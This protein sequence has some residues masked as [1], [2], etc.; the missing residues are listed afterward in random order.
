MKNILTKTILEQVDVDALQPD[1]TLL[2]SLPKSQ[3]AKT[4]A[5]IFDK[6]KSTLAILTTNEKP[7]MLKVLLDELT[8]KKLKYTVYYTDPDSFDHALLWYD[9]MELQEAI[10]AKATESKA[11]ASGQSAEKLLQDLYAQRGTLD[12]GQFI[13]EIIKLTYQA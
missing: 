2:K 9:Q 12:D 13:N 5:L 3:A 10:A 4:K 1:F 8:H 11:Q 7:D 6:D